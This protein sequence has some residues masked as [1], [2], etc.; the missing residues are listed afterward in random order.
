MTSE[1]A[2]R[3]ERQRKTLRAASFLY[4]FCV[5][6]LLGSQFIQL[7]NES[8]HLTDFIP[9]AQTIQELCR[10]LLLGLCILYC[11]F[12]PLNGFIRL[13]VLGLC[14]LTSINSPTG[15]YIFDFA[16]VALLS[17][18]NDKKLFQRLLL[19]VYFV[20][21]LVMTWNTL[22]SPSLAEVTMLGMKD[23]NITAALL[24]AI[25]MLIWILWLKRNVI[26]SFSVFWV[27]SLLIWKI[28]NCLTASLL[29]AIFP[30]IVSFTNQ[31][32][33]SS[34]RK[35]LKGLYA[36]PLLFALLS[37]ALMISMPASVPEP[38]DASVNFLSRFSRAAYDAQNQSIT[39]LGT[40]GEDSFRDNLYLNLLLRR[41]ILGLVLVTGLQTWI[42]IRLE[43]N[44]QYSLLGLQ[45][46]MLIWS[47][48][49]TAPLLLLLNFSVAAMPGFLGDEEE[50][51]SSASREKL[52]R[53]RGMEKNAFGWN[54]AIVLSAFVL[55]FSL[56]YWIV[57]DDWDRTATY[58]T[59]VNRTTLLPSMDGHIRIRQTLTV[60]ADRLD[61]ITLGV[62][63]TSNQ[64]DEA[65]SEGLYIRI[66]QDGKLLARWRIYPEDMTST[67]LVL[68]LPKPLTDMNGQQVTLLISGKEPV[69]FWYG[70]TISAG[71]FDVKSNSGELLTVNGDPIDGELVISQSGARILEQTK[72]YWPVVSVLL[73]ALIPLLVVSHWKKVHNQPFALNT[74]AATARRY[75]Y[76]LRVL[77]AR[78]FK[79]KYRSSMLGMVWSF[80]NP[81]LMT[82]IYMFVF[83]T[84]FQNSIE[85]FIVYVMTGIVLFNYFSDSTT[86][87]MQ[88]IVGNGD[89]INK[90]YIPKYIFPFSKALSS[91]INLLISLIPLILIMALTGVTFHRSLLLLP[92]VI[93]FLI[94]FSVGVGL[95]LSAAL[96]FFRDIQFLWSIMITIFNF[97]C[98]IFYPE[99]IIPSAFRTL[100]HLNPM[101]Q[102]LF[103]ART[104]TLGGVSPQPVTYLYC[105]VSSIAVLLIGIYIFRRNQDHF[106]LY[107]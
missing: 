67:D 103:F 49:E 78:D 76:L 27:S 105:A 53:L 34:Q 104:I 87:C 25:L 83:S 9:A 59:P 3:Y 57:A 19:P 32:G 79:V 98:P 18:L 36:L 51:D 26:V 7:L 60:Q 99:S 46:L 41:G 72:Y 20:I 22:D 62:A 94:V 11:C 102:F 44:R 101:Y 28:T 84:I 8:A 30:V 107:L 106:V 10:F 35:L 21:V 63:M 14:L 77:I 37:V 6:L 1:M 17:D 5:I 45:V 52:I 23:L 39:L 91:A 47:M 54:L 97:L 81:M 33:E 24:L 68:D 55:V 73:A 66:R 69:A 86:L 50:Q 16:A 12:A 61:R 43:R 100:Y 82:L 42:I 90:V 75:S 13:G 38:G 40:A 71:R 65:E 85:N 89:L 15:Y 88:S 29:A 4:Y 31:L 96:V 2:A 95:I 80:L 70:D 48:V 93:V 56:F 74:L 64:R 58:T 92:L